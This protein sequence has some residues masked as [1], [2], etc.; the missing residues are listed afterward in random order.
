MGCNLRDLVSP[1]PIELSDLSGQR[2]AVDVFLN[3]YQFITSMTGEDGKPLSYEGKPVAHL[4]GFLDRATVMI[5]EG[6][7]PVFVFDGRPHELK[8]ETLDGRRERKLEAIARWEAAMEDEDMPAAKKLGPQTAEY[9]PEM[10]EETKRLFEHIGVVWLEAPMEAEG[11]AAV[12]CARGEVGAVASQD[13][14][15]LLYGAPVMVRNLASHGTRRFGRVLHAERIVLSKMLETHGISREQLVDMGIMIGTD[16]HPGIKGIGP[17]TGLKLIQKHGTMEAIAEAKSFD[18]PENLDSIRE[19]FMEHPADSAP[20]PDSAMA[21]E[22]GLR[23]FLQGERGFSE[24]RMDRAINRLSKA[25]RLRSVSQP[26]LF[27]F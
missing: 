18:L 20:L 22:E 15:T 26:T 21:V 3:A 16:F 13:W 19:L 12:R 27:D 8:R 14:D 11:A 17:K 2:V 6:I 25:G 10:V 24:R 4:M 7:D 23:S 1:E 5:S 9:T